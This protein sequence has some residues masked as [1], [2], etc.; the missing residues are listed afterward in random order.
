MPRRSLLLTAIGLCALGWAAP[1]AHATATWLPA[2]PISSPLSSSAAPAGVGP[3]VTM[4]PSGD[5]AAVWAQEGGVY[6]DVRQAGSPS[7][8]QQLV[9]KSTHDASAP[10]VA[11]DASGK[12]VVAWIDHTSGQYEVATRKR[13]ERF[14]APIEAGP[15]GAIPQTSTSVAIDNAG[16]ILLGETK[17]VEGKDEALYAWQPA[18]GSFAATTVSEPGRE[19]YLPVVAM[20]QAG[21]AVVAWE[22]RSGASSSSTTLARALTRPAG[23]AFGAAQSLTDNSKYAF[24]VAVAIGGGGQ[25]AVVWQRGTTSPPYVIEASTSAS[26]VGPLGAPQTISPASGNDES[27]AIAVGGNGEVLATWEQRGATNTIDAASATAGSSFA[28][29]TEVS[30]NGSVGP[31]QVA[32]DAA[33]DALIAWTAAPGGAEAVDA[34]TRSAAGTFGPETTLSAAGERIDFLSS[35]GA[36][37]G[38][39]SAGDAVVGWE[40][41]AE[42]TVLARIYDA[43]GPVLKIEGPAS[44]VAGQPV[45]FTLTASD[46]FTSVGFPT[47][48]FG[49]GAGAGVSAPHTPT[50]APAPTTSSPPRPISWATPRRWAPRS[51]CCPRRP[52]PR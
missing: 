7:S 48:S 8:T 27:P 47:W 2:Q 14:S 4:G 30:A 34:V 50:R 45:A 32:M 36:S 5:I 43:T 15:T 10:S 18:G 46:L 29:A 24:N 6:A 16:D 52:F 38:M 33:G 35:D 40:H 19:G 41:F 20:D 25:P 1:L 9:S 22:E 26:P 39:D 12:V 42:N 28:P 44:A 13:S 49:D 11:I 51:R 31:S 37:A 3:T 23:G 21:D 17:S